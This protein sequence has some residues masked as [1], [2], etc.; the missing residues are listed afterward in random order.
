MHAIGPDCIPAVQKKQKEYYAIRDPRVFASP[1]E[2][3]AETCLLGMSFSMGIRRGI[4]EMIFYDGRSVRK[5][6]KVRRL[7]TCVTTDRCIETLL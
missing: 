1:L 7:A 5:Y 6:T 4:I 2:S 3:L